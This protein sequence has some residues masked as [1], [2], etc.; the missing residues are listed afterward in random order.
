MTYL[1][2]TIEKEY[3]AYT[4]Y[5]VLS[6]VLTLDITLIDSNN[7]FTDDTMLKNVIQN[8]E[9]YLFE[10]PHALTKLSLL[11]IAH[12]IVISQSRACLPSLQVVLR[13]QNDA[14]HLWFF[15]QKLCFSRVSVGVIQ[16]KFP[17][18]QNILYQNSW[19]FLEHDGEIN[20]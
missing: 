10:L 1:K 16:L 20:K 15:E 5:C 9:Q 14:F 4:V 8:N 18:L 13:T 12:V 19:Y 2:K 6:I 17:I 3:I 7:W 11:L